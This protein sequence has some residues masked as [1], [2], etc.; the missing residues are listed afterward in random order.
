MAKKRVFAAKAAGVLLF[1]AIAW[2]LYYYRN[3]N[4]QWDVE[5]L[6]QIVEGFGIWGVIVFVGIA[7][8]RPFLFFPNA[9]I[10]V[11]GGMLYS[12]MFGS[13][14]AIVG[15]MTA[16]SLCY[17]LGNRFQHFFMK[18]AAEKHV[19]KLKNLK[20]REIIRTFFVMRVTPAFP[21]DPISYGAGVTG[22]PFE[23]YF[24]GSLVGI[25]P[26]IFIYTFLGDS[27]DN[28][29]S[30]RTLLALILLMLLAIIP[31]ILNKKGS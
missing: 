16:F 8:I 20:D 13:L 4:I 17:W 29:L 26:K 27:I 6:Q 7:A 2:Y 28:V 12:T 21:I 5:K 15:T 3:I 10:F 23:K 24:I 9:L 14:A 19:I 11:A 18:L 31:V 30:I 25:S 1:L 22:I